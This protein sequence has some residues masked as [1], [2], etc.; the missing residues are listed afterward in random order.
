MG[1]ECVVYGAWCLCHPSD[2]I[3]Y[4]GQTTNMRGRWS[5]HLWHA[6][7]ES[8]KSYNSHLSNWIRKHGFEQV[9]FSPLEVCLPVELD[10]REMWWIKH[11]RQ[12]GRLVNVLEGGSQ[13]RGHKRP[14][15]SI[16]MRG[17][18][19]PMFGTDRREMMESIRPKGNPTD[20][21]KAIW[22]RNR[23]G[24]GNA[25]T[26]LTD[27]DVL[28]IRAQPKRYG[29]MRDIAERFDISPITASAIYRGVTWKHL[30]LRM[31]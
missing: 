27:E 23:T 20:A 28:W 25:N 30:P 7:T 9:V 22:S 3:R 19:N 26:H 29:L 18:G 6:R 17:A 15:Q 5:T 12:T 10:D 2:G 16:K 21:T 8:S 24:Q 13:P 31:C 4:V 14:E 11:F 1:K